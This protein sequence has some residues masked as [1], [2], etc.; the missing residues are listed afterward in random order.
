M[1]NNQIKSVNAGVLQHRPPLKYWMKQTL[2]TFCAPSILLIF[3]LSSPRLTLIAKRYW[4]YCSN[5]Y[6]KTVSSFVVFTT[7]WRPNSRGY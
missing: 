5:L 6:I 7:D 3:F 1:L 2:S 4:G